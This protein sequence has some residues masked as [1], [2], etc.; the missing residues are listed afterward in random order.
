ME[1][2]NKTGESV[3]ILSAKC[4]FCGMIR[5]FILFLI[6]PC[7]STGVLTAQSFVRTSELFRPGAD[8]SRS[9]QLN[10]I[11]DPAIDTL[12]NRCIL[13]NQNLKQING[14]YG[15]VGFRIQIYASSNRMAKEEAPKVYADFFNK[16]P[17][18]K[19]YSLFAKPAY[20]K[21][22]AGDFRTKTEATKLYLI[23]SKEFPDAYLVPDFINYPDLNTK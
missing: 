18:I 2:I 10:I 19:L 12:I 3:F 23:V 15:M 21:I 11:Q 8:N 17:D 4:Y 9:G 5:K 16:F 20:Y 7:L 22:R 14:H 13:I 6:I 1:D